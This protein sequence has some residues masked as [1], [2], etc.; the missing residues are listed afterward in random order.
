MSDKRTWRLR[1][2]PEHV[3]RAKRILESDG[4]AGGPCTKTCPE[5]TV[6]RI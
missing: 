1:A 4:D 2:T 6:I 3:G 5:A